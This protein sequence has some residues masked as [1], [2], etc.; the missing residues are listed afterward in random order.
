MS[1]FH[2]DSNYAAATHHRRPFSTAGRPPALTDDDW[3]N[4]KL[5]DDIMEISQFEA[6]VAP[7]LE[8]GELD[9][10]AIVVSPTGNSSAA[11]NTATERRRR[12]E[13]WNDLGLDQVDHGFSVATN[14][15]VEA[16]TRSQN[17]T[18]AVNH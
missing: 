10:D 15:P 12:E 1:R 14:L 5:E 2:S 17:G 11:A 3:A 6:A 7:L 4:D 8:E 13:G 16:P 9:A 18:P